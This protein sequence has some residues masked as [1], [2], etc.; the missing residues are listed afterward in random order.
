MPL[1]VKANSIN[2]LRRQ[3][4]AF[5]CCKNTFNIDTTALTK[6]ILQVFTGKI[7]YKTAIV[8]YQVGGKGPLLS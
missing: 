3:F 4:S 7:F 2:T 6:Q 1:I 8:S 5:S